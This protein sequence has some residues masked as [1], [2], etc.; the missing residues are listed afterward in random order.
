MYLYISS[1]NNGLHPQ[2]DKNEK[3]TSCQ[4]YIVDLKTRTPV[5]V[6][7]YLFY[8]YFLGE[9][10]EIRR[11]FNIIHAKVRIIRKNGWSPLVY[12]AEVMP[13]GG[14]VLYKAHNFSYHLVFG[15]P[16][17]YDFMYISFFRAYTVLDL[18]NYDPYGGSQQTSK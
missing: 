16:K 1:V 2:A 10:I 12:Y 18:N 8:S 11:R 13:L 17:T 5:P 14:H 3:L 15:Y 6:N 7:I 4:A 9:L